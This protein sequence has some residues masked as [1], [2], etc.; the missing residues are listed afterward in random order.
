VRVRAGRGPFV[1][2]ELELVE[3]AAVKSDLAAGHA[4]RIDL[5]AVD[6][7]DFPIPIF[8]GR[9]PSLAVWYQSAGNLAQAAHLGVAGGVEGALLIG[10]AH[11]RAVLFGRCTF[12]LFGRHQFAQGRR[13]P[14]VDLGVRSQAHSS[15][16][17]DAAAQNLAARGFEVT[18]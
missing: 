11:H 15:Q 6:E 10:V 9:V 8:G 7:V 18:E 5:V 1:V 2:A 17:G 14:H 3:D 4:K 12:D 16:G 13:R